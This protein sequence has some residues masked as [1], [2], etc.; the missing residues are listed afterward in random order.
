M[1][2]VIL[3]TLIFISSTAFGVTQSWLPSQLTIKSDTHASNGASSQSSLSNDGRYMAF[4]SC[5]SN[6]VIEDQARC[7]VYWRDN[8]TGQIELITKSLLSDFKGESWNSAPYI[9]S[10]GRFVVFNSTA[11]DIVGLEGNGVSHIYLW[12]ALTNKIELVSVASDGLEGDLNSSNS[13]VS[14]D[15]RFVVFESES[16]LL[17]VVSPDTNDSADIF[18]RES[19]Q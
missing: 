9:S 2:K 1:K 6:L 12:D 17:D 4:Q 8:I 3:F 7:D 14:D 15:G 19:S 13:S 10:N 18:I 11:A 5:A 16:I